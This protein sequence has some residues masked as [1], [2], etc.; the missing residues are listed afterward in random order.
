[1]G[2]IDEGYGAG[3]FVVWDRGEFENLTER[4][5]R[6]VDPEE[7]LRK[8]HLKFRLHGKKLTGAFTLNHF[9]RGGDDNWL[10][11]K[12]DDEGADRRRRPA[13]TQPESVLSGKTNDD[14]ERD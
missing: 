1:M 2:R 9:R 7:A 4:E 13:R 8:G 11:V 6:P 5:G 3:T 12:V 14:F 10:L